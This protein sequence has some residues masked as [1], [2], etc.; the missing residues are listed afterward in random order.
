M[1]IILNINIHL[2]CETWALL[3]VGGIENKFLLFEKKKTMKNLTNYLEIAV[4][5]FNFEFKITNLYEVG[6][7]KA[8]ADP[9]F[10]CMLNF[11]GRWP[12]AGQE[13][14]SRKQLQ[15]HKAA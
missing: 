4:V 3:V 8:A 15:S 11:N 6:L 14:G 13:S 9:V 1:N 5:D 2:D 10:T 12:V 7:D